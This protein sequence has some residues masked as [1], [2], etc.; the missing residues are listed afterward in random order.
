MSRPTSRD[1]CVGWCSPSTRTMIRSESTEST[2]PL[3]LGQNHRAR[4]ARRDAFHARAHERRF[5]ATAAE[6]T[7]VACS[8]P[9]ARGWRRRAPGTE[10]ATP[11]PRPAASANVDVVHFVPVDQHEVAC[12]RAFTR[13][14]MMLSLASNSTLACAMV[15]LSSSQAD[16]RSYRGRSIGRL[17]A[18]L[19]SLF[20]LYISSSS[21]CGRPRAGRCRPVGNLHIVEAC[22]PSPRYGDSMNPYP[23][24]RAIARQ[25]PDH[26]D[27]WTFWRLNRADTPNA[28]VNVADFEPRAFTR[29]TARPKCRQTALVRDFHSGLV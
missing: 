14:S 7:G 25:R 24:M 19:S 1:N 16:S 29:Q 27:V 9:S 22:D 4:V 11:P 3:R 12:R 15:C 6:P 26:L 8:R 2:M 18:F 17:P 20:G 21:R 5:C 23:L 28:R 13:S 10:P